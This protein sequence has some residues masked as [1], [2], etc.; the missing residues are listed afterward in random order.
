MENEEGIA[1]L[2]VHAVGLLKLLRKYL[3]V[4]NHI[5]ADSFHAIV[6]ISYKICASFGYKTRWALKI[7]ADDLVGRVES[8]ELASHVQ[9]F[10]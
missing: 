6:N 5:L 10:S 8:F 1:P 3:D 7:R 2:L 9:E 4:F